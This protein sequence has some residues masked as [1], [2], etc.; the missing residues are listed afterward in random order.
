MVDSHQGI[1]R[2]HGGIGRR[3]EGSVDRREYTGDRQ[4][5]RETYALRERSQQFHEIPIAGE[6]GLC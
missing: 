1:G 2:R 4:A 6:E 3:R 5:R